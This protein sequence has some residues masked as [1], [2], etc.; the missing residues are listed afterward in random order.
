MPSALGT[1]G[2][3]SGFRVLGPRIFVTHAFVL[4]VRKALRNSNVGPEA[5]S[6]C[7]CGT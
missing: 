2:Y 5:C 3:R 1:G 4:H 6:K 7:F